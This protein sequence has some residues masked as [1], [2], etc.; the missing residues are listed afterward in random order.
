MAGGRPTKY[1]PE[2]AAQAKKLC[3]LGATDVDLAEFFEVTVRT[4]YRWQIER[5]EFCHATK[6][7]KATSDDRVERSLYHRA[8]GYTFESE[9]I[10]T[11]SIGNNQGSSVERVPIVE[12]VPPDTTAMIFWLKNRRPSDW[13]DRVEHTGKDGEPLIPPPINLAKV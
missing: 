2:F 3:N 9:K 1:K 13:R 7:G 12:H 5:K 11:V 4:I 8:I 6:V 10:M